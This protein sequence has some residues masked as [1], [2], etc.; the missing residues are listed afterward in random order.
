MAKVTIKKTRNRR[1]EHLALLIV[2]VLMV[3]VLSVWMF[4]VRSLFSP[5]SMDAYREQSA[6]TN[7]SIQ[8]GLELN[9]RLEG[10]V[11]LL[12]SDPENMLDSFQELDR[13]LQEKDTLNK[14]A[15]E[16]IHEIQAE[17]EAS[18]QL[19]NSPLKNVEETTTE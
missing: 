13:E 18:L 10:Q 16:L 15:E 8:A 19:P 6:Q 14:I 7:A 3:G 2:L 5:E 9:R 17:E 1:K 11:P 12:D 4:Q